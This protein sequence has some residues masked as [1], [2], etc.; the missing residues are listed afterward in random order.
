[1]ENEAAEQEVTAL[2]LCVSAEEAGA[3]LDAYLAAHVA[4]WSRA[5]IKR[6]VE[7]GDVL[8]EGRTV[9]PAYKLRAGEQIEVEL[10]QPTHLAAFTPE[11][12]PIEVVYEDTDVLVVNKP[13]GLIVHPGAGAAGGTLA[14]A[15]AF[16]LRNADC[17]L[18][19]E[20]EPHDLLNPQSVFRIPQSVRPGIVH[21][22]D[23]DTS[24]LL[25]VAKTEAA[26]ENLA[27][28]FRAREV[29]KSYAAL[30]HG[31]VAQESGR[32]EQPIARDPRQRTRMAVV[33]GGRPALSLYSV[34][35]RFERFTLLDVEI[36]TG[37]THQIRVHL[38]WLKHPVVG[39]EVYG[40]GR[41]KT[42]QDARVRSSIRSLR[43]LFLHAEQLGFRHPRT[44]EMLRFNAPLPDALANLL[45]LL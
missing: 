39:D 9:K 27:E 14:N 33:K 3:R 24:G 11:D 44:G 18:R 20:G 25:V 4:D 5:R 26:H 19:N 16:R 12:I 42:V 13:A 32:I 23:K 29:F 8:V 15:L 37:R 41:D 35:R 34:R 31:R 28:Q 6:L 38:A 17:G 22:L 45:P 2:T 36:K 21:R 30:V 40:A 1:M 10:T 7:D 43:R